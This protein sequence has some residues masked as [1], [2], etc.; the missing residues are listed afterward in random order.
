MDYQHDIEHEENHE[1]HVEGNILELN[2]QDDGPQ[3][4]H[5]EVD[6]KIADEPA[7]VVVDTPH[8]HDKHTFP[9]FGLN[10]L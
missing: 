3:Q 9:D 7:E 4:M 6:S 1:R 5:N 8:A 10:N 2:Y